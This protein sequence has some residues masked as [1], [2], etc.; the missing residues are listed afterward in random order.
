MPLPVS[1]TLFPDTVQ[2]LTPPGDD[3]VVSPLLSE[4]VITYP[5]IGAWPLI[6]KFFVRTVPLT[7]KAWPGLVEPMPI[8]PVKELIPLPLCVY[9]P[10]VVIPVVA[11]IW[12]LLLTVKALFPM[13]KV[14]L[15]TQVPVSYTHLH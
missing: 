4:A 6:V 2:P 13:A 9:A 8:L 12:P 7:S 11:V 10:D 1:Y 3:H 14:E 15:G 5:A